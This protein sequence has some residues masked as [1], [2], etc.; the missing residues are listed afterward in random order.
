LFRE[1]ELQ[2]EMNE[3]KQN[4]NL[5][6]SNLQLQ[7]H[8][9]T[10]EINELKKILE[11]KENEKI[12]LLTRITEMEEEKEEMLSEHSLLSQ[13]LQEAKMN[14][15]SGVHSLRDELSSTYQVMEQM[16]MDHSSI[17]RSLQNKIINLENENNSLNHDLGKNQKELMKLNNYILTLEQQQQQQ[18]PPQSQSDDNN[19]GGGG[20]E[21]EEEEREGEK[22]MRSA[23]KRDRI[24][25][26]GGGGGGGNDNYLS[27]EVYSLNTEIIQLSS[28]LEKEKE[29]NG[30][31][32]TLNKRLEK[33]KHYLIINKE[34]E[35][36]HYQ[37]QLN[38]TTEKIK[39]LEKTIQSIRD[40]QQQQQQQ[41]KEE[42]SSSSSSMLSPGKSNY[43]QLLD[44]VNEY[45]GQID[46]LSKMLLKKQSDVMEL[47]TERTALKSR[48]Q[49]L[50][51][52]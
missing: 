41:Q 13:Q 4:K 27:R 36:K 39:S 23:S 1:S 20:G 12:T 10:N 24:G 46:H 25:G 37:E 6:K 16:K 15:L 2:D 22:M 49:D 29:R 51:S 38:K 40:E 44:S 7:F 14:S 28:L 8:T 47:Q 32:E 31:L 30:E 43:Q 26:T 3:I 50:Q 34:T 33:E 11:E 21:E 52:R 42:N 48:V 17:L 9:F 45:K 19:S 5:E 18:P 35:G